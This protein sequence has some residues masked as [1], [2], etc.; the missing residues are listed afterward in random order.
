MER[1]EV[2]SWGGKQDVE[3]VAHALTNH[4]EARL[5]RRP[6]QGRQFGCAGAPLRQAQKKVR[7]KCRRGH[8]QIRV[9]WSSWALSPARGVPPNSVGNR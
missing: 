3:L 4:S 9:T 8:R 6:E 5:Q 7:G 1:E 2:A